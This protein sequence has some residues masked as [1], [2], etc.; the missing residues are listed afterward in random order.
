MHNKDREVLKLKAATDQIILAA[1][2]REKH[3]RDRHDAELMKKQYLNISNQKSHYQIEAEKEDLKRELEE[4]HRREMEQLRENLQEQNTNARLAVKEREMERLHT[5]YQKQ[6]DELKRALS[7]SQAV[8]QRHF[9]GQAAYESAEPATASTSG[10]LPQDV[11]ILQSQ[12][13]ATKRRLDEQGMWA[14]AQAETYIA[15]IEKL[16]SS[17]ANLARH[18]ER[19]LVAI[20]SSRANLEQECERLRLKLQ[21][22]S[23]QARDYLEELK[24]VRTIRPEYEKLKDQNPELLEDNK[25]LTELRDQLLVENTELR[26]E[27][28]K[29]VD[30]LSSET[31]A[32]V[33][34]TYEVEEL[35]RYKNKHS[36][37]EAVLDSEQRELHAERVKSQRDMLKL[38]KRNNK[39]QRKLNTLKHGS[40]DEEGGKLTFSDSTEASASDIDEE[41][42]EG[43]QRRFVVRQSFVL[44]SPCQASR[45]CWT[46]R[47]DRQKRLLGCYSMAHQIFPRNQMPV[48]RHQKLRCLKRMH[49]SRPFARQSRRRVM[50]CSTLSS[51]T[52]KQSLLSTFRLIIANVRP[53]LESRD[54]RPGCICEAR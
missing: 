10:Q 5:R 19:Q 18:S 21:T 20:E 41:E 30:V 13:R 4:A 2:E 43:E 1:R 49:S 9:R 46:V 36:R 12:L 15:T 51:A 50:K 45:A 38:L 16:K 17:E 28:H 35:R 47:G 32:K 29:Y 27:R 22:A 53:I 23:E 25:A 6:I 39:L 26:R 14:E 11:Q 24:K 42:E 37:F 31:T 8:L 7:D 40:L 44:N 3:I 52:R 54:T 34:L 48:K 33:A